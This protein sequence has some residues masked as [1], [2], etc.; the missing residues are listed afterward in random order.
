MSS[1]L[2]AVPGA[3]LSALVSKEAK[4]FELALLRIVIA[5][6]AAVLGVKGVHLAE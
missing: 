5:A 4:P 3:V 1:K 2:K 6:V